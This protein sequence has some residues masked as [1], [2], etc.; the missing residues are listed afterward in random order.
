M[1]GT[2]MDS[3]RCGNDA[4]FTCMRPL[5]ARIRSSLAL[6]PLAAA[7]LM[8][9]LGGCGQSGDLYRPDRKEAAATPGAPADAVPAAPA[10]GTAPASPEEKKDDEDAQS[11]PA[12]A[13]PPTTT[14]PSVT[15]T[16]P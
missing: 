11:T 5:H 7:A 14:S 15:P 9:L 13:P 16:A 3:R 2:L 4:T 12:A 1:R 6:P 10:D 8:L